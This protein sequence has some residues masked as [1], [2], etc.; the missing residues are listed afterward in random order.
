M[1]IIY[2]IRIRLFT[3]ALTGSTLFATEKIAAQACTPQ[4][5]QTTYGTNNVWI[6]YAYQGQSF[7]TYKGYVTEGIAASPNF[8][9]SFGGKNRNVSAGRQAALFV[10]Q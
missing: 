3:L 9:E 10:G 5:D 2:A 4:G 8:D 7:N 1:K 6:G